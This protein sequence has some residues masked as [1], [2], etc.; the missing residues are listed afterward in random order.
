MTLSVVAV[1]LVDDLDAPTALLA[2][3]RSRGALAGG[4]ELPGGKVEPGEHPDE[5][6]AREL[7]EELALVARLGPVVAGPLGGAWPIGDGGTLRV[8]LGAATAGTEPAPGPDHDEVRWLPLDGDP[9]G[10]VAWLEADVPV[11]QAVRSRLRRR[12]LL[13]LPER[14]AA[15]VVAGALGALGVVAGVHREL[16]AGDDDLEDAQW[17][18]ALDPGPAALAVPDDDLERLA[19]AHD[20]WV[21]QD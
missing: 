10:D 4:W 1:A 11:V 12:R 17:V 9:A 21:E 5:A 3:R 2:A 14:D 15:D 18:V 20:G 8:R 19:E 16:L 7:H 13:V 6:L